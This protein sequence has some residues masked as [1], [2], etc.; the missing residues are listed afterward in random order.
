MNRSSPPSFICFSVSAR[1]TYAYAEGGKQ[2]RC[3]H[4][5]PVHDGDKTLHVARVNAHLVL[6]KFD[7]KIL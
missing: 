5:L 4:L 3:Q 2:K 7:P 1:V 6:T